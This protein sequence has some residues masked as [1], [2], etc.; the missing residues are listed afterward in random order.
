MS[1][2]G[3]RPS[4]I[5]QIAET[6]GKLVPRTGRGKLGVTRRM[7]P[8]RPIEAVPMPEGLQPPPVNVKRTLGAVVKR[9]G[10]ECE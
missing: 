1:W 6:F 8:V 2:E 3:N 5:R 4:P 7:A 10:P 9:L